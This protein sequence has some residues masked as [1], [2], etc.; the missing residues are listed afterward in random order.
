MKSSTYASVVTM[1][2]LKHKDHVSKSIESVIRTTDLYCKRL[3]LNNDLSHMTKYRIT[4]DLL[5][6]NILKKVE[7][8]KN[9]KLC[10]S[11]DIKKM[12]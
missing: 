2:F 5:N 12:F 1:V 10:L 6:S 9:I 8:T 4:N 3:K 7:T 11:D